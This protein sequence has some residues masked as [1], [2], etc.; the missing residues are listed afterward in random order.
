MSAKQWGGRFDGPTDS[1]MEAFSE[2][3]SF[4]QRLYRHDIQASLAHAAMLAE[5]GLIT[6]DEATQIAKALGE[7]EADIVAGRM[8]YSIALEDIH[9]HVERALITKLGDIGRKLHTA[10]SRNDQVVTDVKLWVRDAI[11]ELDSR[12]ADLQ[13]AF[14]GFARREQ[15]TIIPG[16]THLQRAQPVLAA[17]AFPYPCKIFLA[18]HLPDFAQP[19]VRAEDDHVVDDTFRRAWVFPGQRAVG[20]RPLHGWRPHDVTHVL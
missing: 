1:R 12:L 17:H 14:V 13:R 3:I 6:A 7:I 9:T 4:D 11:D 10:R 16:Y 18:Q 20:I 2:S 5:V 8:E 19:L 15:A